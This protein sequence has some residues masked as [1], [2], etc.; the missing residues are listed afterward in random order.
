MP[1]PT[2]FA[3]HVGYTAAGVPVVRR[4]YSV[5]CLDGLPTYLNAEQVAFTDLGVPRSAW[6]WECCDAFCT[7][8]EELAGTCRVRTDC[9]PTG[10]PRRL[11]AYLTDVT[12]CFTAR[13]K[14]TVLEYDAINGWWYGEIAMRGGTLEIT[15]SCGPGPTFTISL[16]GCQANPT[17]GSQ[18]TVCTDPLRVDFNNIILDDCC[19]CQLEGSPNPLS[20][21]SNTDVPAEVNLTVVGDCRKTVFAEHVG[22]LD[23]G[24]PVVA[25]PVPCPWADADETQVCDDM[26]CGLYYSITNVSG[27]ACMEVA[28]DYLVYRDSAGGKWIDDSGS[29]GC[30]GGVKT[31]EA[32]CSPT[33]GQPGMLRITVTIVCG[34]SAGGSGFTDIPAE[35]LEDLDVTVRVNL[36][37]S[38]DPPDGECCTGSVDVRLLRP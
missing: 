21:N 34:A 10:I 18:T 5:Q 9:Q 16:G 13:N 27:C 24:T 26:R 38:S 17:P 23:D 15:F 30:S 3:E 28:E 32:T 35:D 11:M 1:D 33:P 19:D 22:Y 37:N 4:L 12:T 8:A 14:R 6:A 31:V 25:I 36:T 2:V 29:W 7:D 20:N